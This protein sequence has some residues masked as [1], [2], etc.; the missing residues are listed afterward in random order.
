MDL[1]RVVDELIDNAAHHSGGL[2][3]L[4]IE[5]NPEP[6]KGLS[7]YIGDTGIGLARGIQRS[8][9]ERVEG[10]L[11]AVGIALRLVDY[12][13]KRRQLRGTS[14]FGG[15]GLEHVRILLKRLSAT[16]WIRSGTAMAEFAPRKGQEPIKVYPNLYDVQGTHIHINIPTQWEAIS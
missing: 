3:Y 4:M 8:Y 15:R 14:A 13:P 7:I 12:L 5:L 1:L 2:G 11:E 10:D 16:A 9:K 6:K